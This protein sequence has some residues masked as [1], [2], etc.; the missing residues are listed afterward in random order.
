MEPRANSPVIAMRGIAKVFRAGSIEHHALT[1][2]HLD[3]RPG[4][5]LAI[6][7]PSGCGKTTLLSL[8]GLLDHPSE[9]EVRFEGVEAGQL[10][11][12][13]RSR[14]RN[15]RI[16]YVFQAF[17][18]ISD[19]DVFDNV[20]L[21]LT[22]RS[23]IGRRERRTRVLRA[24]E[25]VGMSHR[26]RHYPAQLSGGQQQRVAV[27]R[28][29]A[30]DPAILLADEPTGSLDLAS[31]ER[32]MALLGRL[33]AEG[34]TICVVTHEERFRGAADRI[35]RLLD[36]RLVD[37]TSYAEWQREAGSGLDERQL[38]GSLP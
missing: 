17:N 34:R 6:A 25:D 37:E 19:M 3:V 1:D 38:A 14:L 21:P 18:L 16:G 26:V 9:G 30:G 5:F 24:L 27:A 11:R 15:E 33:H 23:G 10:G 22:Y 29:L 4:E 2:I 36:G 20:A 35:V 12:V 31:G 13:A 32:L 28:A 8:M 7:G